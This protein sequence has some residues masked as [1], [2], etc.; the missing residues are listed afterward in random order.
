MYIFSQANHSS[1]DSPTV[2]FWGRSSI[3]CEDGIPSYAYDLME[4]CGISTACN[5]NGRSQECYFDA[6][7]YRS[8][9]HGGHCIGCLDNTDGPNCERCRENFY[10]LGSE[11]GCLPCNCNPV[12]K[13]ECR[14][15][16][17]IKLK[18]KKCN[19]FIIKTLLKKSWHNIW[20]FSLELLSNLLIL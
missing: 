18:K 5:C 15:F 17:P 6:E 9:G 20:Y 4:P 1:A 8:T 11:E 14:I 12:G 3:M 19:S 16:P 13:S 10:R 2:C 7:L